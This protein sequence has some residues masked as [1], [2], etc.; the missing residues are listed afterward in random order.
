MGGGV[1]L[2][3]YQ[4]MWRFNGFEIAQYPCKRNEQSVVQLA[5]V[6]ESLSMSR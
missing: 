4:I 1:T 3:I 2:Q 6:Q 5:L